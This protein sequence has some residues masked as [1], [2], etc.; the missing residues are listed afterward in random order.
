MIGL[1]GGTFDP[2]H[3]GHLRTAL[4]V[5]EALDLEQVRFIPAPRPRLRDQPIA[6]TDQR[7][8]MLR[9]AIQDQSGFVLDACELHREGPSYTI[10]TLR[11]CRAD[12]GDK[13]SLVL[14]MGSDAFAKLTRWHEWENLFNYAHIAVMMR[15]ESDLNESDFPAGWLKSHQISTVSLLGDTPAGKVITVPVTQLA[16]S[17]TDIRRRLGEGQSVRYLLP[18]SVREYLEKHRLYLD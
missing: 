16:I 4:D 1:L 17:A 14:I 10:D 13:E 5:M 7:I 6:S 3:F 12:V 15:P 11:H 9:L 2:I 8:E 18:E